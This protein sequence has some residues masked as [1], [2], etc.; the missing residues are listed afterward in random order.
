MSDSESVLL[1]FLLV[2]WGQGF[3]AKVLQAQHSLQPAL[4][5]RW[6]ALHRY[7]GY[8]SDY[9]AAYEG[10]KAGI[11]E[12]FFGPPHKGVFSPS[13]QFTLMEMGK[14]V[15]AKCA[16]TF[17]LKLHRF[18]STAH[19]PRCIAVFSVQ[20]SELCSM[21]YMP[22]RSRRRPPALRRGFFLQGVLGGVHLLQPAQPPF[23]P[24]HTSHQQGAL[25]FCFAEANALGTGVRPGRRVVEQMLVDVL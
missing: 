20:M 6:M 11:V 16:F 24:L 21:P 3:V 13:V 15:L 9:D 25:Q 1:P 23:H 5:P 19:Q 17:P 18:W 12:A 22:A 8:V 14:A 4:T 7:S 2:R 10:V